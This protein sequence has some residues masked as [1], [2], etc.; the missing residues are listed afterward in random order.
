MA[1][2][3]PRTS[4][5]FP[6]L[7]LHRDLARARHVSLTSVPDY[8]HR[9]GSLRTVHVLLFGSNVAGSSA[10]TEGPII[11]GDVGH[12][13]EGR[14]SPLLNA[15]A[16]AAGDDPRA[17]GNG[18]RRRWWGWRWRRRNGLEHEIE[19]VGPVDE[20]A[21]ALFKVAAGGR[22][23]VH[24]GNR[25]RIEPVTAVRVRRHRLPGVRSIDHDDAGAV[26]R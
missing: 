21:R 24:V 7:L 12:V 25:Q 14:E 9:V 10:V 1:A 5:A 13:A 22:A 3:T 17:D 2:P 23:E 19:A 4:V 6:A 15:V 26:D 20:R 16:A 11:G 18:W 8:R